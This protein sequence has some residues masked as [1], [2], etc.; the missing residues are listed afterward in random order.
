MWHVWHTFVPILPEAQK[1]VNEIGAFILERI[2][3]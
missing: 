3:R 2:A 1:A